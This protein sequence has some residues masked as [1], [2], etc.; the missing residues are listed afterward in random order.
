MEVGSPLCVGFDFDDS[1]IIDEFGNPSH[2]SSWVSYGKFLMDHAAPYAACFKPQSACWEA[3]ELDGG[4]Q[5]LQELIEYAVYL[6]VPLILD[7]KRDNIDRTMAKYLSGKL[8]T[9][10]AGALTVNSYLGDEFQNVGVDILS[11]TGATLFRM[12]KTSNKLGAALQDEFLW[13]EDAPD[14]RGDRVYEWSVK[15]SASLNDLI[16]EQTSGMGAVGAVVGATYP[17]Q[18]I[19]CRELAPEVLFLIPGYGAQGGGAMDA[20]ASFT[21]DG[22]LRGVINTSSGV[23]KAHRNKD[24]SPKPGDPKQYVIDAILKAHEELREATI[25]QVGFNPFECFV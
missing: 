10:G 17:E 4:M 7:A 16:L 11:D 2:I 15:R 13:S 14:H 3:V 6:G 22:K 21:K 23:S 20:V 19:R 8:E 25:A 24:G 5:G 1:H 18:A 12:A 9:L